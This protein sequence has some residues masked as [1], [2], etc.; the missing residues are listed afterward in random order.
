M[1]PV[2]IKKLLRRIKEA[3]IDANNNGQWD[4]V[5]DLKAKKEKV[6]KKLRDFRVEQLYRPALDDRVMS[7]IVRPKQK[8]SVSL[9][10]KNA[11]I[12]APGGQFSGM[13]F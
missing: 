9:P 4:R 1:T 8:I 5:Q 2:E 13:G 12:V 3:I 11:R 10:N 7:C 6:K